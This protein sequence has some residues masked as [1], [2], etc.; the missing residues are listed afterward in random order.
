[1]AGQTALGRVLGEPGLA[2]DL[3]KR[4][5]A[6]AHHFS[7]DKTAAETIAIYNRVARG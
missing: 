5:L 3:R 2:A 6:R 7:W 4:G 1:M